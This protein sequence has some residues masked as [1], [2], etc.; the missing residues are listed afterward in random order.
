MKLSDR[1][2]DL[3]LKYIEDIQRIKGNLRDADLQEELESI[4]MQLEKLE[5]ATDYQRKTF[6]KVFGTSIV[7]LKRV[8]GNDKLKKFPED[9]AELD[10]IAF[11][12]KQ[13]YFEARIRENILNVI[14][15]RLDEFSTEYELMNITLGS[16]VKWL[17]M[18]EGLIKR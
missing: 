14:Q 16:F 10:F 7:V 4:L 1:L 13:I 18:K 15:K 5:S 11:A 8:S 9:S 3:L 17:A 12:L 6:S 2:K